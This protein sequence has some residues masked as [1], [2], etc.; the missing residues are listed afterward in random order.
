MPR[1]KIDIP[2]EIDYLS[3]LDEKGN[4]DD[5][6]E[7]KIPDATLLKL[8]HYMLLGRRFDERMLRLQRQGRIGTFAPISGQEAAHLG[9]VAP[10]RASDWMV[11]A[12]RENSAEMWRGKTME[13]VLLYYNG[14]NE[15]SFIEQ[16][17]NDLPLCVPVG[18]QILHAVGIGWSIKYRLQDDVAMVFFG[19][20][21]TS[22]GDFH[23]G[24]NFA[25]VYQ[26]PVIFICQNNQWAISIPRSQQTRSL[27]LAQK[28]IAYGIKGIQVDGNDILAVYAA[29][30][31]AVQ[32]ARSGSGA[33]L[34][35]CITYR[36]TVHTTADDP[37]R[38]RA[39]EDV[40]AWRKR[41]PI[42]RYQKYLISKGL[43]TVKKIEAEEKSI[44]EKIQSAV[45]QAEE[46]MKSLGDPLNM[47]DHAYAD[48]PP[49]LSEQKEFLARELAEG[50]ED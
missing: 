26:I 30:A 33:T 49:H 15:G 20:G 12:F 37:K 19:D 36:M 34:I 28:A 4:L 46:R 41:D 8:H 38:Y 40:S 45:E 23:E 17:R 43:L 25:G 2:D 27:T 10:M 31:E 5:D 1:T 35:E 44:Q 42:D 14:Y 18:S 11:P 13:S 29:A 24:L 32:R 9:A 16:D 47:F 6:L 50:T 21:A 7:P 22:E 48:M 3:I 39:E